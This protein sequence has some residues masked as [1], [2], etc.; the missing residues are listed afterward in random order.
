MGACRTGLSGMLIVLGAAGAFGCQSQGSGGDD[1]E[2]A[3]E[4]GEDPGDEGGGKDDPASHE[5][6]CGGDPGAPGEPANV[7]VGSLLGDGTTCASPTELKELAIAT[8]DAQGMF[9]ADLS[10]A[11]D[12]EDG[13]STTAKLTCCEPGPANDPGDPNGPDKPSDPGEPSDPG[14]WMWG[15][16]GDNET[17]LDNDVYFQLAVDACD[18]AGLVLVDF[19]T[20]NDCSEEVSRSAKYGCNL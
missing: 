10:L 20:T 16:L 19:V 2:A 12:C 6:E 3:Q 14:N 5:G 8:C 4:V 15:L 9:A 7:C 18:A 11:F 17:C 13:G 1:G